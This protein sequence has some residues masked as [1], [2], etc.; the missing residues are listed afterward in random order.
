[1]NNSMNPMVTV[2]VFDTNSDRQAQNLNINCLAEA[3]SPWFMDWQ[4][5]DVQE[6]ISLLNV[7]SCRVAAAQYLGLDLRLAA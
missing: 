5:A 3:V 1:M 2:S 7:P 4:D 6:A